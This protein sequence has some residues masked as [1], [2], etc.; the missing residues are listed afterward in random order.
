M[1]TVMRGALRLRLV[2]PEV[3][4]GGATPGALVGVNLGALLLEAGVLE[5]APSV[6]DGAVVYPLAL[7]DGVSVA[8]PLVTA[9]GGGLAGMLGPLEVALRNDRG[10]L[11]LAVPALPFVVPMVQSA[12]A[13]WTVGGPVDDGG[14]AVFWL[15][16]TTGTEAALSLGVMG[17]L[18][19][20]V[21]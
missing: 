2:V 5:A 20:E 6:R 3:R 7:P 10:R 21:P 16:L 8:I 4:L 19:I 14:Q 18:G 17:R 11:R 13:R 1:S 15:R 12:L 9:S